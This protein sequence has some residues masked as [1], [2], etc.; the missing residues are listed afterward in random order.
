MLAVTMPAAPEG[1]LSGPGWHRGGIAAGP[2]AGAMAHRGEQQGGQ[3]RA[4]FDVGQVLSG[5][6]PRQGCTS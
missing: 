3:P 5:A 1:Q 2:L 6:R 4:G